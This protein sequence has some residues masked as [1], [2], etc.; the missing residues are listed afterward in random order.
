MPT[1]ETWFHIDSGPGAPAWNMA[2]DEVLL[3]TAADTGF[4]VLRFYGWTEPAGTFGYSQRITD[5]EKVT[6]LRPLIR[7]CTGGGFVPHDRD[8]TYGLAFPPGH[9]WFGLSAQESYEGVHAWLRDAFAI[10]GVETSLSPCCVKEIPGQCFI[11]AEK[12]DLVWHG[13][14]IAGAAQRRNKLGLLIQGSV[15]PP[16]DGLVRTKWHKAMLAVGVEKSGAQWRDYES[17]DG[18]NRRVSELA[19]TRYSTIGHNRKR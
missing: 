6:L 3:E 7:R 10:L 16:F 4:A 17:G 8:W 12:H 11:G 19:E 14:K 1:S 18:L 2:F 5:V 9:A 13:R 15:Q